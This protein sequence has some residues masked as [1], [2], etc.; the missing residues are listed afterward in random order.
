MNKELFEIFKGLESGTQHMPG[1]KDS[2]GVPTETI[3]PVTPES[4][5]GESARGSDIWTYERYK[6]VRLGEIIHEALSRVKTPG[7]APMAE[8][9]VHEIWN[10]QGRWFDE[11]KISS[12]IKNLLSSPEMARFLPEDAEVF[13]EEEFCDSDG[14]L[15]RMDKV[16]VMTGEVW[17]VDFKTGMETR[18]HSSQIKKYMSLLEGFY[19]DK[20]IRGFILRIQDS[21]VEE[22]Q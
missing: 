18:D 7:D 1:K 11:G 6:N 13:N 3:V 21:H 15:Y 4:A 9:A 2:T 8:T 20:K 14:N 19:K 10:A 5:G 17:V 22:I 16:L 12:C